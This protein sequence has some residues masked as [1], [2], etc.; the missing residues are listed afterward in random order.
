MISRLVRV[1]SVLLL[2]VAFARA[3]E[4]AIPSRPV[5]I[6]PAAHPLEAYSVLG[7]SFAQTRRLAE[8]GWNQAQ[9]DAFLEG[10]RASFRGQPVPINEQARALY[11]DIGRR[12][13][14]ID[15]EEM[16]KQQALFTEPGRIESFMKEMTKNLRMQ[17]SDSGLAFALVGGNGSNSR[18]GPDDTVIV[19]C[20]AVAS[21]GKTELPVISMIEQRIKVSELMPG[22]AE[23]VQMMTRQAN[24]LL[25]LPPDLSFGTGEWP[26]GVGRGVPLLY[27]VTLHDI[28]AAP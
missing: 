2:A 19:T 20:N 27:T 17:R 7:S 14:R 16:K 5:P 25:V 8:L 9:I 4:P 13:Q 10:V 24:A 22:L 6:I 12:L 18:P 21:D 3:A 1:M 11:E 28:V 26:P 23:G 15:A